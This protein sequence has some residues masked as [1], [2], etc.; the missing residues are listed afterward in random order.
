M[1]SSL[2]PLAGQVA[3]APISW[4][5]CEVPGWG[6]MLPAERVLPEMVS[7]G[8]TA[9][10]LGA[11]GFLPDDV[12]ELRATLERHH[13]SLVGGFVPLVLHDVALR[14]DAL[15]RA[16]ETARLFQACGATRFVTAVVMDYEWS[17]PTALD[18]DGMKVL[19]EGL[20]QVDE[21]CA[22][23]GLVQALHPHVDTLVETAADVELALELTSVRWC[24]DTGHLS[25]GGT[26]PVAFARE[27][28]D[29]VAHVHLKD[30]DS[31][32][33]PRVLSRELSLVAGVQQG[34]FR[35]L[36]DGDVA[37]DEVILALAERGYDGWYVLEQDTALTQGLPAEG[38][39]PIEDVRRSL[40]FLERKVA[41]RIPARPSV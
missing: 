4:G 35:P 40:D 39:G 22:A 34:L 2:G 33:A 1:A 29:R 24:L 7:L 37:V 10:E 26:D 23:H 38:S 8:L 28:G 41:P 3:G 6:A 13:V 36:G 14:A 5:V 11:P 17:R 12:D 31:T 32:V 9:T 21:V 20:A 16:A 27:A 15:R 19:A 25:I 30:V 18:A